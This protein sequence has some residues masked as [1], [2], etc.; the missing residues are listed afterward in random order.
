MFRPVFVSS[1]FGVSPDSRFARFRFSCL[2]AGVIELAQQVRR[3]TRHTSC[4]LQERFVVFDLGVIVLDEND[5][6][7]GLGVLVERKFRFKSSASLRVD[8]RFVVAFIAAGA[9]LVLC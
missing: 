3:S 7:L 6:S 2:Q 5:E 8:E 9:G 4:G 1:H